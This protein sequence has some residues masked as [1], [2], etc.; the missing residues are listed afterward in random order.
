MTLFYKRRKIHF[1][2][3]KIC[4]KFFLSGYSASHI[5]VYLKCKHPQIIE[6]IQKFSWILAHFISN[7]LGDKIKCKICCYPFDVLQND[8]DDLVP[9]DQ[10]W[11][12]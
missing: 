3:C 1:T 7:T 5:K 10:A 6:E 9:F 2:K 8:I 4:D 11:L 12:K